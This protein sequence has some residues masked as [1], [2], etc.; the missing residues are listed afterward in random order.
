MENQ[1]DQTPEYVPTAEALK[2]TGYKNIRS[3]QRAQSA[4]KLTVKKKPN[5]EKNNIEENF[6]LVSDLKALI[7]EKTGEKVLPAIA[8]AT[9]RDNDAQS[10]S[11]I[12]GTA[13]ALETFAT[14]DRIA[15]ALETIAARDNPETRPA[16]FLTLKDAAKE[17]PLSKDY[18]RE[19]WESGRLTQH[20][21]KR[22]VKL[23]SRKELEN[24]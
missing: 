2:I 5:P 21:G 6:Y 15:A 12:V 19:L 13:A 8:P 11:P 1:N 24:L 14:F 4:G 10:L 16:Q 3:L 22:N 18:L 17:F 23:F 20:T 9:T 7:E